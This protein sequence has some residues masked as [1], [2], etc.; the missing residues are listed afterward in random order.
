VSWFLG[1]DP[2]GDVDSWEHSGGM[3][4]TNSHLAR[5]PSGVI[6]AV[7]TNTARDQDFFADLVSGLVRAV[8]GITDWPDA[9]L[10]AR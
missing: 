8:E 7:V 5:L 2:A 3:P 1:T 6:V 4:G 10:F 9:D